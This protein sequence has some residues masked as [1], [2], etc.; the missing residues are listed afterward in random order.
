MKLANDESFGRDRKL[1]KHE[2]SAVRKKHANEPIFLWDNMKGCNLLLQGQKSVDGR[3]GFKASS[4]AFISSMHRAAVLAKKLLEAVS[5]YMVDFVA[6]GAM[7]SPP[8]WAYTSEERENEL[9][10]GLE[11]E[12]T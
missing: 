12:T 4:N 7:P 11:K 8:D 2:I 6:F 10:C 3:N 1:Y 9:Y 5:S